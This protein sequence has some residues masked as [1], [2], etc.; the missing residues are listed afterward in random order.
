MPELLTN[1]SQNYI[2]WKEFDEEGFSTLADVRKLQNTVIHFPSHRNT[3]KYDKV[4]E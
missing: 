4:D 3:M 2:K 1:M